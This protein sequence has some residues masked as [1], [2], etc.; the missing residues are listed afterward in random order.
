MENFIIAAVITF[1]AMWFVLLTAMFGV[2]IGVG[3]TE[4]YAP[5]TAG[6]MALLM[7]LVVWAFHIS[8][9]GKPAFGSVSLDA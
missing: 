3:L 6:T 8:L 4:W 2:P 1:V 5:Y 7:G 9:G